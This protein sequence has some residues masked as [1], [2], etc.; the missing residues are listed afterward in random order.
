MPLAAVYWH[1]VRREIVSAA[2]HLLAAVR[3][4]VRF[5]VR[6]VTISPGDAVTTMPI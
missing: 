6:F 4:E 5:I 2:R 1:C 3:R